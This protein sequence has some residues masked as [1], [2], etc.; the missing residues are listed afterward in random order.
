MTSSNLSPELFGF[1]RELAKNNNREWFAKN[2]AATRRSCRI[3]ACGSS[4]TSARGSG[5]SARTSWRSRSPLGGSLSRIYRDTRFSKDKSPYKTTV[6]IHFPHRGA[7]GAEHHVP[8]LYLHLAPGESF[9]ASG[10]WQPD[11]PTLKKIRDRI[12]RRP[13]SW[14]DV[15]RSKPHLEGETLKRPPPGYDADHQFIE[16]VKRKDFVATVAFGDK[17]VTSERFLERF[18]DACQAMDPLNRFLAEAVGLRW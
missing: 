14:E 15:L 1:L 6:V 18:V 12:V 4:P 5:A 16:D 11:P 3:R 2:K 8:G 9:A 7:P 10:V 13:E 17:E